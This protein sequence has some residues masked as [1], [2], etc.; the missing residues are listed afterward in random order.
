MRISLFRWWVGVLVGFSSF[1][2]AGI[3][4]NPFFAEPL[5]SFERGSIA[6]LSD[7]EEVCREV[8]RASA[9]SELPSGLHPEDLDTLSSE[10]LL[11]KGRVH[12]SVSIWI[13]ITHPRLAVSEAG[14][15]F[16]KQLAERFLQIFQTEK[17]PI[18]YLE[19]VARGEQGY[20]REGIL[21]TRSILRR[22][23]NGDPYGE[24]DRI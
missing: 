22:L 5:P 13:M 10:E 24:I 7:V 6:S 3:E 17:K 19:E 8:G 11:R 14:Y 23:Q 20:T 18:P 16:Q 9:T 12:W 1:A 2:F 21:K 4:P 15:A